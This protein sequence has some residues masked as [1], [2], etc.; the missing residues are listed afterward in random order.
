VANEPEIF[1]AKPNHMFSEAQRQIT[2]FLRFRESVPC[3]HCGKKSRWHWTQTVPFKAAEFGGFSLKMGRLLEAN[4]PVCRAHIL[5][6]SYIPELQE[7][8]RG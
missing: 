6:P 4:S 7:V 5:E 1:E 8:A 3:A 2:K